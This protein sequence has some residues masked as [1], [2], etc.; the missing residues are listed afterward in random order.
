MTIKELISPKYKKQ[1]LMGILLNVGNQLT[2]INVLLFYS[3]F[4]YEDAGFS[5]P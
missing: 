5:N 2:G 3:S 4:I 1:F